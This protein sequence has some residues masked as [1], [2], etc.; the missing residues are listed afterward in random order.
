MNV[1]DLMVPLS[2]CPK[3]SQDRSIYE[4]IVML[5]ADRE[6]FRLGDYPGRVLLAEDEH[7]RVIGSVLQAD[8]M[9]ALLGGF[10]PAGSAEPGDQSLEAQ[11]SACRDGFAFIVS[12]ARNL[13]IRAIVHIPSDTEYVQQDAPL[14]EAA[15]RLL[16]GPYQNLF[17]RSGNEVTGI[18]RMSDLFLRLSE[19]I[20]KSGL[21]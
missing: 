21:S 15:C 6:R 9:R 20:E 4:A 5:E 10:Q 16:A 3:V 18:L 13:K 8:M 7:F 1:K 19:D 2:E 11:I 17:V 14:E 12:R